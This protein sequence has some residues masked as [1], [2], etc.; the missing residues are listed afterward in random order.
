MVVAD[1][2]PPQDALREGTT[3]QKCDVTKWD[4]IKQ[5]FQKT[6]ELHEKIDI[7]CANAGI[8][9]PENLLKN[10]DLEP[11]WAVLDINLKGVLMSTFKRHL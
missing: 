8:N 2:N 1:I 11:N 5:L 4:E 10:D 9:D 3:F 6:R 7:V